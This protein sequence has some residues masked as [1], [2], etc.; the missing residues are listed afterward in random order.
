[1]S[2]KRFTVSIDS[3]VMK[4]AKI[5]AVKQDTNLSAIVEKLLIQ[6]LEGE[7]SDVQT[8]RK[9]ENKTFEKTGDNAD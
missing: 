8:S 2:K 4:S 5:L 6:L 9:N 3:E 7:N 1:M